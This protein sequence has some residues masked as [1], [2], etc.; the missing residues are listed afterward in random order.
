MWAD[1]AGNKLEVTAFIT[2]RESKI[3]RLCA[4]IPHILNLGISRWYFA[5]DDKEMYQK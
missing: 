4:H 2:K 5:K 1:K 3:Y